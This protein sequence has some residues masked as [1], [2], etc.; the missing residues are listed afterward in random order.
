M[1]SLSKIPKNR[2][3]VVLDQEIEGQQTYGNNCCIP[4]TMVGWERKNGSV[5]REGSL[6]CVGTVKN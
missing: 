4:K 3:P 6:E 1:D 2:D 5:D